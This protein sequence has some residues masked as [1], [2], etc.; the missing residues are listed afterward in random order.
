[1]LII[2]NR[3]NK[4]NQLSDEMY[5]ISQ[6]ELRNALEQV[7]TNVFRLTLD[8]TEIQEKVFSQSKSNEQAI[9]SL[10]QKRGL[11][12]NSQHIQNVLSLEQGLKYYP[13]IV[14][15]G[16]PYNGKSLCLDIF[17]Q[18]Q[19]KKLQA[20]GTHLRTLKL[21]PSIMNIFN[22]E[23]YI[24]EMVKD[25]FVEDNL[26]FILRRITQSNS[27]HLQHFLIF[28]GELEN[29]LW[30]L[31]SNLAAQRN[32]NCNKEFDSD[33]K[34][35][36]RDSYNTQ[37]SSNVLDING[38]VYHF[39]KNVTTIIETDSLSNLAPSSLPL[40]SI[41]NFENAVRKE[42]MLAILSLRFFNDNT[43]LFK[44]PTYQVVKET[45]QDSL[46]RFIETISSET[47]TNMKDQRFDFKNF[48]LSLFHGMQ[49]LINTSRKRFSALNNSSGLD[50]TASLRSA[51]SSANQSS[52]VVQ[53]PI[54]SNK[55]KLRHRSL[56]SRPSGE[57]PKQIGGTIQSRQDSTVKPQPQVQQQQ[58]SSE[59][60]KIDA[61]LAPNSQG[62]IESNTTAN[63]KQEIETIATISL[64]WTFGALL[65]K[66]ERSRFVLLLDK[67]LQTRFSKNPILQEKFGTITISE[68][69]D[70][71]YDLEKDK[72]IKY[73]DSTSFYSQHLNR[74]PCYMSCDYS[75][76]VP[77]V[78]NFEL[79]HQWTLA[80]R[81][82]YDFIIFSDR[83]GGKSTSLW[84][85]E[86]WIKDTTN[87][88]T[89]YPIKLHTPQKADI[90]L[91]YGRIMQ[92]FTE[93][94]SGSYLLNDPHKIPLIMVDDVSL[95]S[96][97][98]AGEVDMSNFL[99][100]WKKNKGIYSVLTNK[101]Y[102]L[103][104]MNFVVTIREPIGER[105]CEEGKIISRALYESQKYSLKIF[106]EESS[107]ES[108]YKG[109]LG[110]GESPKIMMKS[111]EKIYRSLVDLVKERQKQ[112]AL[113]LNMVSE[114]SFKAIQLM[115][116]LTWLLEN[117]DF[118]KYDL[119]Y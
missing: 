8:K 80:S 119:F 52:E 90:H 57:K 42:E 36:M 101:F 50:A 41:V 92:H 30:D 2:C 61:K 117:T 65:D 67:H 63:S 118:V 10:F 3:V 47:F 88:E 23:Y 89:F 22:K 115:K 98:F 74:I 15:L 99:R 104:H 53:R 105:K 70:Y 1:M 28:D 100:F 59:S 113:N 34:R 110:H 79:I 7:L 5:R 29:D 64:I 45:I 26:E 9:A 69:F 4:W 93:S 11:I 44:A 39:E 54:E 106:E 18:N 112:T 78:K 24:P 87:R 81:G 82:N 107:L 33:T 37:F 85:L 13:A 25:I 111:K 43:M 77:T 66:T 114:I 75:Y 31:L 102:Q 38:R 109:I 56:V 17:L 91:F 60:N 108:I 94:K 72:F 84:F 86:K 76:F 12:H 20:Q 14:L 95:N 19:E 32:L 55:V 83:F 40:F 49:S 97:S 103:G 73:I 62:S 16:G 68:I 48:L 21:N 58:P 46:L 6:N 27:L 51:N 116:E 96:S 71:Y 35:E